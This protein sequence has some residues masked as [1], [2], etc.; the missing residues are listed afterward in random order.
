M[1]AQI[2]RRHRLPVFLICGLAG[3]AACHPAP[4]VPLASRNAALESSPPAAEERPVDPSAPT[5]S[6]LEPAEELPPDLG[7]RNTGSDW[8]RFLGPLADGKSSETGIRK[9]WPA[10]GPPV[11]WSL[12]VGRG[13]GVPAVSRG[14][15]FLFDRY[16]DK[17]R[18]TCLKAET[19]EEL[20]RAEYATHY[21]G[22]YES[23]GGPVATPIVDGDRVYTFGIEGRLRCHRAVDG[24]LLWDVD[25]AARFGV[26]QDLYGAGS[27][28]W[29][30][31]DLLIAVIGGS[32]PGSPDIFTDEVRGNGSGI[33]AFDKHTG[34]VRYSLS[35]ELAGYSSP[36]VATLGG[37][38]WGF[39]F[40]R[41][42]LLAF[43]PLRGKV[44]FSFPWRDPEHRGINAAMPVVVDDTVFIT[45]AYGMGGAMLRIRADGTYEVVWKDPSPDGS[46]KLAAHW[47]TPIYHRGYLYGMSGRTSQDAEL[48][49]VKHAT[50]EVMWR[51]TGLKMATL[52]YADEHLIVVTEFGR[53]LLVKADP[54]RFQA[55]ADVNLFE[56]RPE[57]P[58][59]LP[60]EPGDELPAVVKPLLRYP[61]WNAPVLAH[62]L[63]YVRGWTQLVCFDLSAP[64]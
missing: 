32:P 42:G 9:A 43:D 52:L 34:E 13:Y 26:V 4:K 48:R 20:W 60:V 57:Y 21:E 7:T 62:G 37:R 61:V 33:V 24:K 47:N 63:L 54:E 44:D 51:K 58:W 30:E 50:G 8:P 56:P 27:T 41:G 25:T 39:A 36:I 35:D 3:V 45:E 55:V 12:R 31:G 10:E 17:A 18:L 15:L 23:D 28:P 29:I 19:G 49:C 53:M 46:K 40:T 16:Q 5:P 64:D 59:S 6:S 38:R 2:D 22:Y 14:R 11:R 1:Q